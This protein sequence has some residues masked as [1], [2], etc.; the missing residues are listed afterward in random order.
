MDKISLRRIRRKNSI[1]NKVVG[2]AERPRMAVHKSNR[3]I[4]VQVIDDTD[5]KTLCGVS[6]LSETVRKKAGVAT[7]KNVNFATALGAAIAKTAIEKGITKV[8]FDRGGNRYHGVV[9]AIAESAR[10]NGL[11]F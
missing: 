3:S 4:Y 7:R 1:R 2:T 9:K 8:V 10:K 6:T 11:D 5:G